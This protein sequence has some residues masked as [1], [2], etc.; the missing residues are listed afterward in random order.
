[1]SDP[2]SSAAASRPAFVARAGVL[3]PGVSVCMLI[4]LSATF[5]SEHYGG[6]PLLYALLM[7]LSLNF[8]SSH[9]A[10]TAGIA[11]CAKTVL[12]VGVAL[13]GARITVGQVAGLGWEIA[14]AIAAGVALTI[15]A[16]AAFAALLRRPREHGLLAG[17]SVGICG[18]S[19]AMAVSSVL[20]PTRENERFTLLT[21]IGVTLL[22]TVAM[23]L[24]PLILKLAGASALQSGVFLGGTIHDVAQVVAAG[25]LLGPQAADTAVI[26]K[27]YRVALL[28]PAAMA[29]GF[30]LRS[31][32]ASQGANEGARVPLLPGFMVAFIAL[33][34]LASVGAV[35]PAMADAA[36]SASRWMLVVAIGAAGLKTHFEELAKLGWQPLA[37]LVGETLLLAVYVGAVIV[38]GA[39]V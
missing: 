26:V 21:V 17:A 36:G 22:S 12:R 19:A 13:L 25:T 34:V 1:M 39:V 5:V 20:P 3:W 11:F 28:A 7:G 35:T 4:A 31:R 2:R 14:L 8:L 38:L 37:M 10:T 16:G 6:P 30:V 24:Y 33:V 27:L 32:I 18:A 9:P 23:V 29:I 15:G